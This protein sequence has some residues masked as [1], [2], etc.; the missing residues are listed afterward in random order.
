[1]FTQSNQKLT[2]DE[3][4]RAGIICSTFQIATEIRAQ[5]ITHVLKFFKELALG[6]ENA[7]LYLREWQNKFFSRAHIALAETIRIKGELSKR[8]DW[9]E[10]LDL[11]LNEN[12]DF[13]I[14]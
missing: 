9:I 10:S 5:L 8:Q 12:P 1:L 11:V 3:S 4:F 2:G 13:L 6:G 14:N 7:E